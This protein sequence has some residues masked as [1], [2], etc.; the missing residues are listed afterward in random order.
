[1]KKELFTVSSAFL[2]TLPIFEDAR[3]GLSF[4]EVNKHVP[5]SIKRCFWIFDVPENTARGGHAHKND[6]QYLICLRGSVSIDVF[7]FNK[8]ITLNLEGPNMGLY[9]PSMTWNNL[10]SFSSNTVLLVLSSNEFNADDY[11]DNFDDYLAL[12]K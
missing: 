3:G 10:V 7:H 5:F 4:A 12:E 1:M 9:L 6:H 2:S 11:I 8:K